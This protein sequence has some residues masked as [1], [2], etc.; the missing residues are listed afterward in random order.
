MHPARAQANQ[1]L[2]YSALHLRWLEQELEREQIP[3]S[4]VLEAAG[5]SVQWHVRE[6]Y[7]WF[8]LE[9]AG[10]SELPV[11][12][13]ES[14]ERLL[15][16]LDSSAAQRGELIELINLERRPSWLL[17]LLSDRPASSM[18]AARTDNLAQ[19]ASG[20][21][22]AELYEWQQGVANLIERMSDSL[23]EW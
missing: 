7:G 15:P 12:P 21:S 22:L 10:S 9:L 19:P 4:V 20:W 1:S 2:Y 16:L 11:T 14:L 8:L 18:G 17:E 6:A 5:R 23:E 3:A 13:P